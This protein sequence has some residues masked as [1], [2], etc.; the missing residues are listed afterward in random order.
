MI[1]WGDKLNVYYN[2][3][4]N[5]NAIRASRDLCRFYYEGATGT[6]NDTY[7]TISKVSERYRNVR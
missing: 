6:V 3:K 1:E 2:Q 4:G 5:L 7:W